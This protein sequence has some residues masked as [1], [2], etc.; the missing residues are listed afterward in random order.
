MVDLKVLCRNCSKDALIVEE[1][2]LDEDG[3]S[4]ELWYLV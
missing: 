2:D 3:L 4:D 1:A